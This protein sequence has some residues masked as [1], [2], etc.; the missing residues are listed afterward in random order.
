M[1]KLAI[2]AITCLICLCCSVTML[3]GQ[4]SKPLPEW[5][6][7]TW[8]AA[9]EVYQ[10]LGPSVRIL[11]DEGTTV[12]RGTLTIDANLRLII[13]GNRS[14]VMLLPQEKTLVY[15][16]NPSFHFPKYEDLQL[17]EEK[18]SII[19]TWV[20][21]WGEEDSYSVTFTDKT[22]TIKDN[23]R[24]VNSGKFFLDGVF[25]NVYWDRPN[26]SGQDS[27][28]FDGSL[29][30][31][32]GD[33]LVKKEERK[34]FN[35][36]DYDWV[37]G[38]WFG[39]GEPYNYLYAT[40]VIITD[41]YWQIANNE[42]AEPAQRVLQT[43]K[44][45]YTIKLHHSSMG[46]AFGPVICDSEEEDIIWISDDK[47]TLWVEASQYESYPLQR[48]QQSLSPSV[49]NDMSDGVNGDLSFSRD[50]A[51]VPFQLAE[52]KP[53]F[54]GGDANEFSKWVNSQLI[55]P[56]TAKKNGIQG[57]VKTQF[58]IDSD[59]SVINVKVL[60]GVDPSLDAEAVRVISGSPKWKPGEADGKPVRVSYTFPV[61]FQLR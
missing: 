49:H 14:S 13:D 54:N 58:I 57:R 9:G 41:S 33:C 46:S 18:A 38:E 25:V 5:L 52:V 51:P 10:I 23:G 17:P 2:Y 48:V 34:S 36:K 43:E 21:D 11:T 16:T 31:E 47:Q 30:I 53:S 59:G 44:R 24:I 50:D 56:E 7:G 27:F 6:D 40:R 55:Y 42:D 39:K 22:I 1:K 29:C 35:P 8:L 32:G 60:N 19:G 37:K 4:N 15:Y 3:L 12:T 61:I 20:Y 26:D 45:P 28:M